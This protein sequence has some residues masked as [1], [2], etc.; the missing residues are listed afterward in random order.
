MRHLRQLVDAAG[1]VH[2]CDSFAPAILFLSSVTGIDYV[3]PPPR[4]DWDAVL[5]VAANGAPARRGGQGE[6]TLSHMEG[7]PVAVKRFSADA[8]GL[9]GFETEV[10][11]L[12]PR[13]L[14]HTRLVSY[15]VCPSSPF[16]P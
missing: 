5:Q 14:P 1:A 12:L 8:Q 4:L 7:Q 16:S 15:P 2:S 6:V 9:R 11:P 10:C 3:P 13:S